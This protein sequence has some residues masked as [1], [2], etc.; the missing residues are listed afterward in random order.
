M[1]R[2]AELTEAVGTIVP[3][4]PAASILAMLGILCFLVRIR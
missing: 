4:M 3:L 2:G 1:P